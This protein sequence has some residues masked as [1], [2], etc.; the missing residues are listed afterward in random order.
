[1]R[2]HDRKGTKQHIAAQYA[3]DRASYLFQGL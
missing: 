3:E 2:L 1:M